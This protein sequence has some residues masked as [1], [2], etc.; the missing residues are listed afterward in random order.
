MRSRRADGAKPCTRA[1]VLA[2]LALATSASCVVVK[3]PK[4]APSNGSS[5][6]EGNGAAGASESAQAAYKDLD[7]RIDA[8]IA[9]GQANAAGA[10]DKL[11]A[12]R[13]ETITTKLRE[14]GVD[15]DPNGPGVAPSQDPRQPIASTSSSPLFGTPS[16]AGEQAARPQSVAKLLRKI[17]HARGALLA[18]MGKRDA[19]LREL[20]PAGLWSDRIQSDGMG[21]RENLHY[22]DVERCAPEEARCKEAYRALVKESGGGCRVSPYVSAQFKESGAEAFIC[23]FANESWMTDTQGKKPFFYDVRIHGL[24]KTPTGELVIQ[25]GSWAPSSTKTCDGEYQTDKIL[26]VTDREIVVER[27]TWCKGRRTLQL[28]GRAFVVRLA[29]QDVELRVGDS[30]RVFVEPK[31]LHLRKK[32]RMT[33]VTVNRPLLTQVNVGDATRW[34]FGSRFD[35]QFGKR[36]AA[37]AAH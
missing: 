23:D 7:A 18:S 11:A 34:R 8:A 19:L 32:G 4:D 20:A 10:I 14:H 13:V 2:A 12:L 27:T 22:Q 29:A 37:P 3:S 15:A 26:S 36:K 33:Y 9:S 16:F 25:G 30:I 31:E 21:G 17:R 28:D 5:E 24:S 6:S 35:W 1:T